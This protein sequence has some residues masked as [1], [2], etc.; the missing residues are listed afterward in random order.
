MLTPILIALVDFSRRWAA[1]LA[2]AALVAT[3]ALGDYV[4]GHIAIDTDVAKLIADDLP[5]R[6]REAAFDKAFPQFTDLIAVVIDARTPDQAD[7]AV[8]ALAQRLTAT[9]GLFRSVRVPD[10]DAFFR[11]NG[12]LFLPSDEVASVIEQ[13]IE[14][15]PLIGTLAADPSLRGLMEAF[16]LALEGAERGETSL[17]SLRR[18]LAA[19]DATVAAAIAG[20][21][22]RLS[23]QTLLTGREAA[24]RERR[25]F[26]LVQPM[27][28]FGE[29]APGGK[30]STAIREAARSLELTPEHGVRVRLTGPV[31]LGDEEFASVAEGAVQSS[32]ISV[33][34]VC[35]LL[36]LALRSPGLVL[37][38]LATLLTGLAATAAFALAAVGNLNVISIAFA[39]LFVGLGVDFSIQFVVRYRDERHR[40]DDLA[41][42]LRNT[43]AGVGPALGLAAT[44]A[45]IGFLSFTPTEYAGV[46]E[47]GWIAGF[48][49]IVAFLFN[50]A[51]LPALIALVRPNG[52]KAPVGYAWAV[53][54]DRFLLARRRSV[55][56]LAG[57]LALGCLALMPSVRFDFDPLNLKDPRS[58][59]VATL[60]E[61]MGDPTTTPYTMNVLVAGPAAAP[62]MAERLRRLSEVAEVVSVMSF[63]PED[64]EAKLALIADAAMLIG[65]SL[66]APAERP[67]PTAAETRRAVAETA[68]KL[69]GAAAKA[70]DASAA[71]AAQLLERAAASDA[72]TLARVEAALVGGLPRQLAN[73]ALALEAAPVTL[74]NLPPALVREWV[75]QDGRARLEAFPSGDMRS[76]AALEG[77]VAAVQS[78]APA[79]TGT[80][81]VIVESGHTIVSAFRTAGRIATAAI[82]LLLAIVLRRPRDVLLVLAPLFLA[83]LLTMATGVLLDL[84]LNYANVIT[85]P[86]LLGIGVAFDVYFVLN[87]RAGTEHPLASATARAV[88]FSAGTTTVAFGGLALSHHVGTAEMG[89]LLTMGLGYTVATTLLVLPALLGPPPLTSA[90]D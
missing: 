43:A 86:L 74:E 79:A 70:S 36:F 10:G 80:P 41:L 44:A 68:R 71:Q 23:W 33:A 3:L 61:L 14:A 85:L 58:E 57:A 46:R 20:A 48:G 50:M 69:T 81:V 18:P 40:S 75:A 37:A 53:G 13:M 11:R 21:S 51:L 12:L 7:A 25:R 82:A 34:L 4:A 77:F 47:L 19:I 6:Q 63:V 49:M 87:W 76:N 30:P 62:A 16:S 39:V 56:S 78:V 24:P 2:L 64:Q 52:E 72:A 35:L 67:K 9:P 66:S 54:I 31:P 90:H 26:V 55:L 59:S 89:L 65:P 73:L 1:A 83:G 88:L 38:V 15:Q 84:P 29:L 5:W 8:S 17:E 32:T 27:L 22:D 45:S 28:D 42:A 60:H